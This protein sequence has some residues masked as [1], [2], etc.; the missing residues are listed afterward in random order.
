VSIYTAILFKVL[1]TACF[2]VMGA[3]A[4][5][6]GEIFPVGQVVFARSFFAILPVVIFYAWRGEIW[7]AMNT[8]RPFGH[9]ARG[10]TGVVSMFFLFAALARLPIADVTAITFSTP[11]MIVA[12]AGLLLGERVRGYR[13]TA[14]I[15]GLV[16]VMVILAPHL[17]VS[18]MSAM[19]GAATLGAFFALMNAVFAAAA[20]IQIR[21][22]TMSETTSAIVLYFSLISSL[23][24]LATLPFGWVWPDL[25]Q[26]GILFLMGFIG[27]IGQLFMTQSYRYAQASLTA[28][29]DYTSIIWAVILGYVAFG[30]VPGPSVWA[31]AV[32]VI[33]A[34]MFVIWRERQLI[35]QRR[36]EAAQAQSPTTPL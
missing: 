17:S 8:S 6:L 26:S 24:G 34:G 5:W 13:W 31:G 19:T 14:V 3:C 27:G 36:R 18:E 12:L 7:T 33:G 21:R 28:P 32:I 30:E 23:C 15:L 2:A 9:V 1:S 11:L 22:L 20:Y 35:L 29:F 10:L 16:G 4:R 25:H